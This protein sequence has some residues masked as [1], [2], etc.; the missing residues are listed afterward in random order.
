VNSPSL[1]AAWIADV[2]AQNVAVANPQAGRAAPYFRS[3]V[4]PPMQAKGKDLAR[5][6]HG[7]EALDRGMVVQHGACAEHHAGPDVGVGADDDIVAQLR[8]GFDDGGGVDLLRP[9]LSPTPLLLT[10]EHEL[11]RADDVTADAAGA[12]GAGDGSPR[13]LVSLTLMRADRRGA[14]ACG[15]SPCR[16]HE[17]RGLSLHR[18]LAEHEDAGRLGHGLDLQHAGHDGIAGIVA[19]KIR[20]VDGDVLDRDQ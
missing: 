5:R 1:V 3:C 6:A 17:Q 20:L 12:L 16:A 18:G 9:W 7:G 14:R 4:L 2:F 19:L 10:I 15:T 11:A 13:L 8:T